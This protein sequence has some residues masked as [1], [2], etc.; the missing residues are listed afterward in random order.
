MSDEFRAHVDLRAADLARSGLTPEEAR[1]QARLEFGNTERYKDE[2]RAS[3]GLDRIND[4]RVSWLDFKLGFRMLARYPGLTIV[5]GIAMAFAIWLG[6]GTFE[7]VS[8]ALWPKMKI[9]GAERMV[10]MRVWDAEK[11][12][13]ESRALYEFTMWRREL[14][15]L[16]DIGAFRTVKRNLVTNDGVGE[17]VD[18]AEI[19]AAGFRLASPSPLLGRALVDADE[20]P[21]APA[22]VVLGEDLWQ[23]RLGGDPNIIGSTIQLGRT[24]ATVVGVLPRAYRFPVNHGVW[25]PLRV[26]E[27]EYGPREGPGVRM[28]ARLAPGA[29]MDEARAELEA[30]GKRTAADLPGTHQH[31]RPEINPYALSIMGMD[32]MERAAMTAF[33]V[34]LLLLVVLI[35]GNVALLIFARAATRESELAVRAALGASRAR[36]IMQLFAEALVLG[37]IAAVIGLLAAGPGVAWVLRVA[38]VD[39]MSGQKFPFWWHGSL[40]PITIVYA[41]A[42]T[43]LAAAIAGVL[44]ALKMTR[45]MSSLQK[46]SAGGTG[47]ELGGIWTAVVIAQVAITV[48][49]PG[50]TFLVQRNG[51]QRSA[52]VGVPAHEYLSA[53]IEMDREPPPGEG[54]DTSQAAF[55]VRYARSLEDVRQRLAADPA[56]AGVTFSTALP[57]TAHPHRLIEVDGGSVA[58][59]DPRWPGGYRVSDAWVDVAYFDV[60]EAPPLMG[61]RFHAGDLDSNATTI[62]VNQSFVR[63]VL[64]DR[65]PIG[66]R[67]RYVYAGGNVAVI[68]EKERGPWYEI[69]GVV[70]DLGMDTRMEDPKV[71]GF[72][73]PA[74]V[75]RMYPAQ[76]AVH[77]RGS[78]DAFIP[79][80]RTLVAQV[81]PTLRMYDVQRIDQITRGELQGMRFWF[82]LFSGISALA[83]LLSLAGIY[84][85]MSFT[86]ARRTR[87]IG[88]RVALGASQRRV[89]TAIFR[90]PVIQ[91]AIGVLAGAAMVTF[92]VWGEYAGTVSP[93]QALFVAAYAVVMMG[94]CLLACLVPTRRALGVEPTEALRGEG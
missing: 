23:S 71:A 29:S 89:V 93:L 80:L 74:P 46:A 83:L 33:Q 43:L 20:A 16:V 57:G 47:P 42:L 64:G 8:Q 3:R 60:L 37:V 61:R 17:P 36:I 11:N 15:S 45:G 38:E 50:V 12:Q 26:A 31:L 54:S 44:P 87:E 78:P 58:P 73:H 18:I 69:V 84:A 90:R 81:D 34:P 2:A 88:I 56:V 67:I 1:R 5:G 55:T 10:G 82:Q 92:V 27:L 39:M 14:R 30:V 86:V 49:F 7:L 32:P 77:V 48:A 25:A 76:V 62:V 9:P 72:Y 28:F 41:V 63:R 94:V 13:T 85:V 65:N 22:V 6:A 75:S 52:D 21:G 53:R 70:R 4:L 66:R 24:A 35:C 59:I 68:P 51:A 19:S 40:S 79:T 91:V